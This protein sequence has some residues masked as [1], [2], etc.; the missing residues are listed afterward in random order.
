MATIFLSYRRSDSAAMCDRIYAKLVERFGANEVFKDIDS[1]P[2]GVD[3]VQFIDQALTQSKVMLVLIG[4]NW[5]GG[6][7]NGSFRLDDPKDVVRL[8]L[9]AGLR[10]ALAVIP[11]IVDGA[12]MPSA[13]ELPESLRSLASRNGWEV[14]PDPYFETDM[15]R[16][17]KAI[18]RL[19]PHMAPT[20]KSALPT[21]PT[22]PTLPITLKTLK[23]YLTPMRIGVATGACALLVIAIICAQSLGSL[24]LFSADTGTPG[25]Q[26]NLPPGAATATSASIASATDAAAFTAAAAITPIASATATPQNYAPGTVIY[27]ADWSQNVTGW[28]PVQG[29]AGLQNPTDWQW[30]WVNSGMLGSDGSSASNDT[31]TIWAPQLSLPRNYSVEATIAFIRTTNY[32]GYAYGVVVR[33]DGNTSGYEVG[34]AENNGNFYCGAY[35]V[36]YVFVMSG[37]DGNIDQN[38]CQLGTWLQTVNYTVDTDTHTFRIDVIA[39]TITLYI[40]GNKMLT[41]TDNTYLD[42]GQ[43]GLCDIY[44]Q[45]DVQSFKVI[46]L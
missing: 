23:R 9:E 20:E 44:A 10:H 43:V 4:R 27:Q 28:Q 30:K 32:T 5:R 29:P 40:D 15:E 17:G 41:T 25:A 12:S 31:Y 36:A 1:I 42:P 46:A 13:D 22:L 45:I 11:I 26:N 21:G 14:H 18:E 34:A 35:N 2:L 39:N 3:F 19:L 8:E 33:G 7:A 6:L 24:H 16:I 37:N 38:A